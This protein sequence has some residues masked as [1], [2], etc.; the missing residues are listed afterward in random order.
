MTSLKIDIQPSAF[1]NIDFIENVN[2]NVLDRLIQS[3][4]LNSVA[5]IGGNG[6]EFENEKTQLQML[7]KAVNKDG[8][9]K[10]K[11]K[12]TLM[13][14][15]RV[16][17]LKSNS[18]GML[19][20]EIR[21]TLCK[22][23]YTDL[24]MVNSHPMILYQ[25]CKKNGISHNALKSYCE[26]REN[27]L[28]EVVET[29]GV[30]RDSAKTLFLKLQYGGSFESWAKEHKTNKPQ[31]KFI[32]EYFDELANVSVHIEKHNPKLFK[33]IEKI[34]NE[35]DYPNIQGSF[36]SYFC[37]ELERRILENMYQTLVDS[38]SIS[39]NQ[40][41][42]C[43][44]GI[45]ILSSKY[46]PEL[47]KLL[48]DNIKETFEL[49]INISQK[50]MNGGYTDD[51]L[52]VIIARE[53]EIE[54]INLDA[55][56]SIKQEFE[57]NNFK[58][59]NPL[60]YI[61][62]H[63]GELIRY[64]KTDFM[65]VYENLRFNKIKISKLGDSI[66]AT[67]FISEWL[68]DENIRTYEKIDMYPKCEVPESHYN[69][70]TGFSVEKLDDDI[71]DLDI[72][73]SLMWQ[74]IQNICGNDDKVFHYFLK[75]LALKIQR[76]YEIPNVAFLFQSEQGS[77][78]DT[79]FNWFGNDI[80]GRKYYVNE[81]KSDLIFGRF[82]S[83]IEN[84]LLIVLNESN[85]KD[86]SK[87]MDCLK[88][89]ITREVNEIENKGMKSYECRNYSSFVFLTNN[90]SA[91]KIEPTDRR[92][93]TVV[94]NNN[95]IGDVDYFNNLYDEIKN[96][97]YNKAWYSYFMSVDIENYNFKANRPITK[98]YEILRE[99][100][101]P[102]I[103]KFLIDLYETRKDERMTIRA[104]LFYT[105]YKNWGNENGIKDDS[106][107]TA[108]KFGLEINFLDCITNRRTKH[109]KE[110]IIEFSK[111][112]KYLLDKNFIKKENV[113]ID[114]MIDCD[115]DSDNELFS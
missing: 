51:Q 97:T 15:G 76:P 100:S 68:K 111:L 54:N 56:N 23:N 31:S 99:A 82:N 46:K 63:D 53:E 34:Q 49:D 2:V 64:T 72:T 40:C 28:N 58:L 14:Y 3:N 26:D 60:S 22:D 21:H 41:I 101:I 19:R 73:K 38:K 93:S 103:S 84:K 4:L 88:N 67:S 36:L 17:A 35:K 1:E 107:Y 95:I 37:Q 10:V 90:I 92:F 57:K 59:I 91:L 86:N 65:S 74:H 96:K 62:V 32:K 52:P 75:W 24:D 55:Y 69:T 80:L 102:Q 8:K 12:R 47:L 39:R 77:G 81:D 113:Q 13:K 98:Y 71:E 7:R 105:D 29:Y 109:G 44:D 48:S 112:R 85:Q 106:I 83:K 20:R 16:Y 30:N 27:K 79:L 104:N 25:L 45:M 70:F 89:A 5:W 108:T 9:L 50:D 11:Y 115:S 43:F 87:I 110:Y 42:L 6:I 66:V 33:K 114:Y 78:K 61:R 94:C 18:F